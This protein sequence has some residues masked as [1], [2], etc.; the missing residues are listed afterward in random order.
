MQQQQQLSRRVAVRSPNTAAAPPADGYPHDYSARY[1]A[2]CASRQGKRPGSPQYTP[3]HSSTH[4]VACSPHQ[5]QRPTLDSDYKRRQNVMG[6]LYH[7]LHERFDALAAELHSASAVAIEGVGSYCGYCEVLRQSLLAVTG[8]VVNELNDLRASQDAIEARVAALVEQRVDDAVRLRLHAATGVPSSLAAADGAR[9][10]WPA[11]P[12]GA[13]AATRRGLA[14]ERQRREDETAALRRDVRELHAVC[15]DVRLAVAAVEQKQRGAAP[16][17]GNGGSP[18]STTLTPE[19]VA[20]IRRMLTD[21]EKVVQARVEAEVQPVLEHA[22]RT[23][24]TTRAAS[25]AAAADAA[26]RASEAVEALA[27]RVDAALED[28]RARAHA[29]RHATRTAIAALAASAR[30]ACPPLG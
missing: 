30:V 12:G 5:F 20:T 11:V 19:D 29:S 18:L 15:D 23:A 6:H 17:G 8:A 9:D 1:C 13:S 21:H 3:Q 26:A 28:V 22:R 27:S 25:E 4:C 14:D 10:A 7:T 16:A 2:A 24:S